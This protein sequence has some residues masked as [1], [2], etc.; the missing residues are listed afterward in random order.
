MSIAPHKVCHIAA[1]ILAIG[2]AEK[3]F[4]DLTLDEKLLVMKT[5][6]SS[7]EHKKMQMGVVMEAMRRTLPLETRP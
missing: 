5:A 4:S 7:L 2:E 3:A 1:S 6:T